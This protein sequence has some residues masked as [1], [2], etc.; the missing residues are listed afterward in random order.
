MTRPDIPTASLPPDRTR[1]AGEPSPPWVHS[2]E[3]PPGFQ[4]E[5]E[6]G[7]GGMGVVYLARQL[8]LNR[9]V[10]LK[11]VKGQAKVDSK[12]LIRFLAEAEA[13]AAVRHK[14]VVEVYQYGEHAGRP[15][16]V[17]EYCPGG[18]LTTLTNATQTRD[19]NWFRKVAVLTAGIADGVNAAHS[20][21][22]VHRDLKPHN[23]FLAADGTPKVADFGLAKRG[24]GSDLT[25]SGAVMGT[26]AYMAPEQAGGGTK[27]VGPEADVWALGVMLYELASGARPI[28]TDG[29]MLDA[30]ARVVKADVLPLRTQCPAV[31]NDLALI[32]HKC[33]SHDPRDRYPTAGGLANDL[34]NWLAGKP[35]S[36]RPAWVIEQAVKW[37]RRNRA[38]TAWVLGA[39]GSLAVGAAVS[40]WWAAKAVRAEADT[41]HQLEQTRRLESEKGEALDQLKLALAESRRKTALNYIAYGQMCGAAS[42]AANAPDRP[43]ADAPWREFYRIGFWVENV[44]EE[45]IK[46]AVMDFQLSMNEWKSGPPPDGL[47][48]KSLELA[49]VCRKSWLVGVERDF[50]DLAVEI[51]REVYQQVKLFAWVLAKA[52][53]MVVVQSRQMIWEL[54]WGELGIVESP[55]VE[56]AM[57]KLGKLMTKWEADGQRPPE[58]EAAVADLVAACDRK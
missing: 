35:I 21:G 26:P 23:V 18:D 14:N 19:A 53:G 27:F 13:V 11:L 4:I 48:H 34:R 10:A 49:R 40:V 54:Y 22:I 42:R 46:N 51:R 9:P 41:T 2:V 43:G 58:L 44:A 39:F 3:T 55:E 1:T 6:L 5:S 36:A 52:E 20:L 33:L 57:V 12:A 16:L 15:Y 25:N 24:V 17:L 45:N 50:P 28:A 30:I 31:P 37:A 38:L 56:A 7:I 29:P 8:G 47:K 32:A